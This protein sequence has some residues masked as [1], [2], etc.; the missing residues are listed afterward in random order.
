M[1]Y[2]RGMVYTHSTLMLAEQHNPELLDAY[3]NLQ[4]IAD[5]SD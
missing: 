1:K 4:G 3:Q 2:G 5:G